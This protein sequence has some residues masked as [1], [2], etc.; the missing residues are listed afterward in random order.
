MGI[1]S[2]LYNQTRLH[3]K[4]DHKDTKDASDGEVV[5][6]AEKEKVKTE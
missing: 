1:L 3:D 5:E 6:T 4:D 2:E